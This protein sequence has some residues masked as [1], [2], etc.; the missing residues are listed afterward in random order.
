MKRS[1]KKVQVSQMTLAAMFLAVGFTLPFFTGQIPY[2]GKMLLPMHLPVLVCGMVCGGWYGGIVGFLLPLMCALLCGTPAFFPMGIA[3]ALELAMYGI[4][5]GKFYYRSKWKC[6]RTLYIALVIA[7]IGGRLVWG[8]AFAAF[9]K[10]CGEPFTVGMFFS[11]AFLQAIPGIFVQLLLVPMFVRALE[12]T[13][14][15]PAS[16]EGFVIRC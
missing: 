11:G 16:E 3:M 5:A 4:L 1:I 6:F 15:L 14:L 13:D 8:V 7:M 10:M 9:C 12:M 2:I